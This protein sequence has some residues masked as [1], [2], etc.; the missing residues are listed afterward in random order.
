M[1]S[2]G[3]LLE[4]ESGK[5]LVVLY[6]LDSRLKLQNLQATPTSDGLGGG[7]ELPSDTTATVRRRDGNLADIDAVAPHLRKRATDQS[8]ILSREDQR[9]LPRFCAQ[10]FDAEA[11]K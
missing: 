6:E 9:L 1:G 3:N 7:Q 8:I 11:M 4:A 10:P 5:C 2:F